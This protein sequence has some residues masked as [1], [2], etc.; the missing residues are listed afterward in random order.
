MATA[1]SNT[2]L[3]NNDA[4]FTIIMESFQIK[5]QKT[6]TAWSWYLNSQRNKSSTLIPSKQKQYFWQIT[7]IIGSILNAT[8]THTESAPGHLGPLINWLNVVTINTDFKILSGKNYFRRANITGHHQ[9]IKPWLFRHPLPVKDK[10]W[11]LGK[12]CVSHPSLSSVHFIR[13]EDQ[14]L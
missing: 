12:R 3:N 6:T 11:C 13:D 4:I 2:L 10:K 14:L 8:Q 1:K 5:Q 7:K 9:K